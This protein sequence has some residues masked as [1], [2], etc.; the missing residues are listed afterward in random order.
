MSSVLD[1]I[2]SSYLEAEVKSSSVAEVKL[3]LESYD[4]AEECSLARLVR[5]HE[6]LETEDQT[7]DRYVFDDTC[8]HVA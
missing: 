8:L 1:P 4:S 6:L 3:N 2:T 5:V 7:L